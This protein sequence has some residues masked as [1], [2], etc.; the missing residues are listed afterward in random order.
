MVT[1]R[2]EPVPPNSMLPFGTRVVTLDEAVTI[3]LA[4]GVSASPTLNGIAGVGVFSA[5]V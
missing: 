3:R 5:V 1:V 2:S 4:A